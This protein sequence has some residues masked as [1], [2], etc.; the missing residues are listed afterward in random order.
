MAFGGEYG[1]TLSSYLIAIPYSSL[2]Q[3]DHYP[4]T[5]Y[6]F[7]PTFFSPRFSCTGTSWLPLPSKFI[8]SQDPLNYRNTTL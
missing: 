5:Y 1:L 6:L 3:E 2:I 7:F 4:K 8:G